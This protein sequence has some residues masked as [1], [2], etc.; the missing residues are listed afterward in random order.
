VNIECA[1][2]IVLNDVRHIFID[3]EAASWQ[4][5]LDACTTYNFAA[6]ICSPPGSVS[7][8]ASFPARPSAFFSIERTGSAATVRILAGS[9]LGHIS[10]FFWA[11]G[12][13]RANYLGHQVPGA[14]LARLD[15]SAL[16]RSPRRSVVSPVPGG[17]RCAS[18]SHSVRVCSAQ[19]LSLSCS[20][21]A[22]EIGL[23]LRKRPLPMQCRV[24]PEFGT[25]P[26]VA[27]AT[28]HRSIAG[29]GL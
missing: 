24:A 23:S 2:D 13:L 5:S 16:A 8:A 11:F 6:C 3:L 21:R 17:N 10:F 28:N 9:R 22:H 1:T 18:F 14:W 15:R 7:Y 29:L 25:F 27:R 20:S 12:T 4:D 19:F 26:G